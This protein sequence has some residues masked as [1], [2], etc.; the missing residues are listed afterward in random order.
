[1]KTP[2]PVLPFSLF[3]LVGNL[4]ASSAPGQ[5]SAGQATQQRRQQ[6]PSAAPDAP[7]GG[8]LDYAGLSSQING[9]TVPRLLKFSGVFNDSIGHPH[10]GVV[11]ITFAVYKDQ[12]GGAALWMET[13]NVELDEQGRYAVLL[14]AT[15]NAG[16]PMELFAAAEP[17]WL[18]VQLQLPG[19]VEQP[20]VLL[21]TVPYAMK[22]ADAENL[23]GR[24]ASAYVLAP[25]GTPTGSGGAVAGSTGPATRP[26]SS[27]KTIK[28]AAIIGTTSFIPV[29]TDN[30][31]SLGN[32][33]LFQS[34]GKIGL[35]T[36]PVQTLDVNGGIRGT[37]LATGGR[38]VAVDAI[39][40]NALFLNGSNAM[41]VTG[42][43]TAAFALG[44]LFTQ[45]SFFASGVERMT[46]A[47]DTGNV[48]IGTTT[49]NNL[50]SLSGQT[51]ATFGMDPN[52]TVGT[53]GNPLTVTAGPAATGAT[54]QHGG[55]LILAA[56]NGTGLGGGGNARI[57]TAGAAAVSGT[58][59]DTLSDRV[60]VVGKAKALTLSA[61][62]FTS[63][64][65]IHLVGTQTAGGRVRYMVRATDG[66]SQI[67]TEEGVIQYLATANSI[68]CTVQ[69][70]DK[71][72]LGTVNSGCTPGF[73][74]PGS[75]PGVSIFDNV[76]FSSPASIVVHEVYF[77]I[78]NESGSTI[79]LEP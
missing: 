75:Q 1:M 45:A 33:V 61:P 42:T 32:S 5:E 25:V 64:F 54:D 60:I 48:G 46:I 39:N 15:K 7:Q 56:G 24:P 47:G 27:P 4:L 78:E 26:G 44:A 8:Q 6:T 40:T 58:A 2:R 12:E 59:G 63:L 9:V 3:L 49:P 17:R 69:T 76:S 16:V 73:F 19:E 36:T 21:V 72:H 22:A 62:G 13:Q 29:F 11:G 57:Q 14:G 38:N 65:S 30:A 74:N 70:T 28:P 66:G 35:G 53:A 37:G 43:S 55:D 50:L 52:P 23:G 34:G 79:R 68:T 41:G 77:S 20:R 71:L 51:A 18:G 10:T 31:G 67:A